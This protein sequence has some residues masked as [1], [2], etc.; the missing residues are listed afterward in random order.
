VRRAALSCLLALGCAGEARGPGSS[1]GLPDGGGQDPSCTV[2]VVI[3]EVLYD[4]EGNEGLGKAFLEIKGPPGTALDGWSI[5]GVRST[6][7]PDG[8]PFPLHGVIGAS[9]Y[10]VIGE[11]TSVQGGFSPDLVLASIDGSNSAYAFRLHCGATPLDAVAWG[12]WSGTAPGEG[13]AAPT[14]PSGHGLSR[15]PDGN[16]T[17]DNARDLVPSAITP[18]RANSTCPDPPACPEDRAPPTAGEVVVN[19][20]APTS[21]RLGGTPLPE[22]VELVNVSGH[23]V[24]L[25]GHTLAWNPG[26]GGYNQRHL[27]SRSACLRPSEALLV[28]GADAAVEIAGV[29][30]LPT[31][32]P[33]RI[34]DGDSEVA[35]LGP[36]GAKLASLCY[37]L[38]ECP[39][40]RSGSSLTLDPDLDGQRPAVPHVEASAARGAPA[41]PGTCQSGAAFS[42]GCPPPDEPDT[43]RPDV[44]PA[45]VGPLD[46]GAPDGGLADGGDAG[47]ADVAAPDAGPP[48]CEEIVAPGVL[49]NE[50]GFDPVEDLDG[51]GELSA[52]R[53]EFVELFNSG[54]HA[55]ELAGW[56]L[57]DSTRV[58]LTFPE[59]S[60][61]PAGDALL[62]LATSADACPAPGALPVPHLCAGSLGLNNDADAVTLARDDGAAIDHLAYGAAAPPCL[63]EAREDQSLT[64]WPDGGPRWVPHLSAAPG[65]AQSPGLRADGT[66]FR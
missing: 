10:Y 27:L 29:V 51:D 4:P 12:A 2:R 66:P 62:V 42:T 56:T 54:G 7:V 6:G 58:R 18:G 9:G 35:L 31:G 65:R 26:Q 53:D 38:D 41:S 28:W 24:D 46:A 43:G 3:N 49:I 48:P 47:V 64:R 21:V 11:S 14:A 8:E 19:E 52:T 39:T 5:A 44:G 61:V 36:G 37:G 59:G 25:V 16:D 15:C 23:G 20:V 13:A 40:Y 22:F 32:G 63:G 60:V 45:D 34:R 50:V 57:E 1:L 17:G 55:V 30:V 33:L